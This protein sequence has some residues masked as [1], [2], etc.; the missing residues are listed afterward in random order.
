MPHISLHVDIGDALVDGPLP[1][2]VAQVME[3]HMRYLGS[4][5]GIVPQLAKPLATEGNRDGSIDPRIEVGSS[6]STRRLHLF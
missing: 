3:S 5:A 2:A 1:V 4:V 6:G